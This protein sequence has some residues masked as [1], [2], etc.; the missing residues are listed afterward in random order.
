MAFNS[1]SERVSETSLLYRLIRIYPHELG[2]TSVIWII[3]FFYRFIFVLSW[4]LVVAQVA[5]MFHGEL[6]LPLLFLFHAFLVFIGSITSYFLF[7][8]YELEYVFL[9]SLILG[10]ILLLGVQFFNVS[11]AVRVGVLLFVE[12]TILVQLSINIETFTERLFSPVESNRTFP[13]VE[14]GDTIATL[15]AG[16]VL[17]FSYQ[18]LSPTRVIWIVI[19]VLALLVPLFLQY[20]SFIR[21]LPGLCLYR[22]QLLGHAKHHEKLDFG[23]AKKQPYIR[24]L[25]LIVLAQWF[26]TV[27]LEFLFTY[28]VSQ[29]AELVPAAAG[30]IEN[31]LIHEFGFIQILVAGVMLLSHFFLAGR[32]ISTLGVTGSMVLHP[33]IA[34]LSLAGMVVNFGYFTTVLARMNAE[35]TGVIFRN[36]YQSSYYLFGEMK[37]QFVRLALDGLIRPIGSLLGTFFLLMS[38]TLVS[39]HFYIT[40][41][42]VGLFAVL[43]LFLLATVSLQRRYTEQVIAQIKDPHVDVERKLSLLDILA[44]KGHQHVYPFLQNL[45]VS[46]EESPLVMMK[47]ID[48]FSKERDFLQEVLRGLSHPEFSVRFASLDALKSMAKRGYFK[49]QPLSEQT[50][51]A[52]LKKRYIEESQNDLRYM[53]LLFLATFRNQQV[54]E[55]LLSLLQSETGDALGE[56]ILAC[57][58]FADPCFVLYFEDYLHSDDPRVWA[59]A[60]LS[61]YRHEQ[62]QAKVIEFLKRKLHEETSAAHRALAFVL[63]EISHTYF[64]NYMI[65]RMSQTDDVREKILLAFGLMK[66]GSSVGNA[67]FLDMIFHS[68]LHCAHRARRLM[69]HLP[70]ILQRRMDRIIQHYSL[71]RLHEFLRRFSGG[72][73]HDL[74]IDELRYL[75]DAYTL[76]NVTEEIIEI[77]HIIRKKDPLYRNDFSHFGYLPLTLSLYV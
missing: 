52:A 23:R 35:V 36:A 24:M 66:L 17:F 43:L 15:C 41:V 55:Y 27:V 1:D 75:R 62:H 38:F 72:D 14:S 73:L 46:A 76:L 53:T 21:S 42:L 22:N 30:A 7:Q 4:T 58:A 47:L 65:Q 60:A 45:Y 11:D 26:F 74:S 32:F 34:L 59:S 19:G 39:A 3:R 33:V 28:S 40:F 12:S 44:Q 31:V 37:S 57:D 18:Q 25:V 77:D 51:I 6:T 56:A 64:E 8:K 5:S 13:I 71:E 63:A 49:D 29:K 69:Y 54:L 16:L 68:D 70:F 2:R 9:G 10:V 67:A 61:L 48:I 20:N 50:I